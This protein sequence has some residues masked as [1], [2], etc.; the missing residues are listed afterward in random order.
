MKGGTKYLWYAIIA[1]AAVIVVVAL[2]RGPGSYQPYASPTPTGS[3]G[4]SATP[5]P[6]SSVQSSPSP[7]AAPGT[8]GDAVNAYVGRR[9]QFDAM[10]QANPNSLAIKKGLAIMF[11]NRS[12][13]ARTFA[14]G[15]VFFTLPGYGWKIYIP[16]VTKVPTTLYIDCGSSRNVG[17]II[18]Q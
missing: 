14:V 1:V 9:I 7:T 16:P 8:Y 18:V 10:C 13:D 5:T 2:T 11:D 6:K 17:T 3:P 4:A 15:G 12:G